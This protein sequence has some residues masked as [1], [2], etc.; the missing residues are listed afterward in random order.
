VRDEGDKGREVFRLQ[1]TKMALCTASGCRRSSDRYGSKFHRKSVL[2]AW[3]TVGS[4]R[5]ICR[6]GQTES[7]RHNI[8]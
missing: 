6:G 8:T 5:R 3:R 2:A 4:S 7:N 1:Q